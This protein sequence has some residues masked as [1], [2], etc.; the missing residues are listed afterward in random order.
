MEHSLEKP[1][2]HAKITDEMIMKYQKM[3]TLLNY[4]I[5]KVNARFTDYLWIKNM[6]E[7][8]FVRYSPGASNKMHNVSLKNINYILSI[9]DIFNEEDMAIL[10]E[11]GRHE[12]L[13]NEEFDYFA[14]RFVFV[15]NE[16]ETK[17]CIDTIVAPA[18]QMQVEAKD[19]SLHRVC[20]VDVALLDAKMAIFEER[21]QKL[22]DILIDLLY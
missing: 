5:E 13:Y 22:V 3:D 16:D 2:H 4:G 11:V 17:H 15:E 14:K 18:G 8:Y 6:M 20:K 7:F 21:V 12:D 19:P 9:V 1:K 10:K